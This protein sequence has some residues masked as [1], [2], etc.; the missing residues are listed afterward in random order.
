MTAAARPRSPARLAWRLYLVAGA[1]GTL[2][3]LTVP[4]FHGSAPF[5]NVLGVTGALAVAAGIRW[6]RPTSRLPWLFFVVGLGLFWLGDIYTYSYPKL[7]HREVPFP[8]IGDAIYLTVYPALMAGLLILVRRRNPHRKARGAIDVTILTLGLALPFWTA[9]IA[10]YLHDGSMTLLP[11][12]V[13]VAYPLGDVL[14]LAAALSLAM[15]SGRRRPAFYLLSAS[16]IAL[17]VTDFVYGLM[18]LHGSYDHQL[19]LDI[20]WIAFY[21]LWGA[22]ALH[23]SMRELDEP[24]PDAEPNA[25]AAEARAAGRRIADRPDGGANRRRAGRRYGPDRRHRRLD[26]PVQ[27]GRRADGGPRPA[28][29]ALGGARAGPRRGGSSAG[30]GEE[31]GGD[32]P[33]RPRF[34]RPAAR[35][36]RTGAAL[37]ARRAAASACRPRRAAHA[38]RHCRGTPPCAARACRGAGRTGRC[39]SASMPVR[40]SGC[41]PTTTA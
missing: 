21:L 17:L 37:P 11:K 38:T 28:A 5:M 22:A 12:L 2:L 20:G 40:S 34:D 24:S 31:P 19:S 13:S 33:R 29:G 18:L 25:H 7:V 10:P 35:G 4:P 1:V 30:R 14:L 6:H 8:S 27:L 32:R 16:I 36:P 9:L 3:Y 41:V 26:R 15:D 23:P 39:A